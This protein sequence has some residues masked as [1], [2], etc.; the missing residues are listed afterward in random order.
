MAANPKPTRGKVKTTYARDPKGTKVAIQRVKGVGVSYSRNS[1]PGYD[2][3]GKQTGEVLSI[4]GAD[5]KATK[6]AVKTGRAAGIDLPS[7][8]KK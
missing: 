4:R 3:T 5:M 6:K 1:T 8:K 7:K 2:K